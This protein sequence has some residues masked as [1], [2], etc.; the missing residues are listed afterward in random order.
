MTTPTYQTFSPQVQATHID[1][2]KQCI[3][4]INN[5]LDNS[6]IIQQ[7]LQT[8]L[9]QTSTTTTTTSTRGK[10]NSTTNNNNVVAGSSL[11]NIPD[12]IKHAIRWWTFQTKEQAEIN[13]RHIFQTFRSTLI[14]GHNHKKRHHDDANA[15][16]V[17]LTQS[18]QALFYSLACILAQE[19]TTLMQEFFLQDSTM[20]NIIVDVIRQNQD[21][22]ALLLMLML[23]NDIYNPETSSLSV[24]EQMYTF[25]DE[26]IGLCDVLVKIILA[27][28]STETSSSAAGVAVNARIRMKC[29]LPND[30]SP[31]SSAQQFFLIRLLFVRI[32]RLFTGGDNTEAHTFSFPVLNSLVRNGML[33][34][35]INSIPVRFESSYSLH[36]AFAFLNE[37][38]D[39]YLP[40][41]TTLFVHDLIKFLTEG[42]NNHEDND[43]SQT[44]IS[45]LKWLVEHGI[46][47]LIVKKLLPC[48]EEHDAEWFCDIWTTY[49]VIQAYSIM[50]LIRI[51]RGL[52]CVSNTSTTSTTT[53]QQNLLSF[54]YDALSFARHVMMIQEAGGG[55]MEMINIILN[56]YDQTEAT[57][58]E[59]YDQDDDEVEED[60]DGRIIDGFEQGWSWET[61]QDKNF[62][63]HF[64]TNSNTIDLTLSRLETCIAAWIE[65]HH[66]GER[67]FRYD[68]KWSITTGMIVIGVL[69]ELIKAGELATW[70]D[71]QKIKVAGK[72]S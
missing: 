67:Y 63:T 61:L 66:G 32:I 57:G 47:S 41:K 30:S 69:K 34:I 16:D 7:Q 37:D 26:K 25:F 19:R 31:Q 5:N 1:T 62:E 10:R 42:G 49:E 60:E 15:G 71:E 72:N 68:M 6:I 46:G 20:T 70:M 3:T 45:L 43:D 17:I 14:F 2:A 64:L 48:M 55:G 12:G 56:H 29:I 11:E 24:R 51:F 59:E 4:Q 23:I 18:L 38:S 35:Y 21:P 8:L 39:A 27:T 36:T 53:Q 65:N 28:T 54:H 33:D 52:G 50:S 13:A 58:G 9:L 40:E 22:F 44:H